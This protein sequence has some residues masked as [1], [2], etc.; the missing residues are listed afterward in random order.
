MIEITGPR[1]ALLIKF[2]LVVLNKYSSPSASYA[3]T[4]LINLQFRTTLSLLHPPFDAWYIP[5]MSSPEGC[6][7]VY[8]SVHICRNRIKGKVSCSLLFV[9]LLKL[10][11]WVRLESSAHSL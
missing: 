9:L 10:G 3:G 8:E 5:F 1:T 6:C 4:V 2:G 11:N 7:P